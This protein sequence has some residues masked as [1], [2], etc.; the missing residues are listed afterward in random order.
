[1]RYLEKA[2]AAVTAAAIVIFF[3]IEVGQ[4]IIAVTVGP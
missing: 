1:M 4:A 2:L 3:L